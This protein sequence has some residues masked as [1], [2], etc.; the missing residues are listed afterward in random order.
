MRSKLKKRLL[1]NMQHSDFL[2]LFLHGSTRRRVLFLSAWVSSIRLG[3]IQVGSVP[4]RSVGFVR[5]S[6]TRFGSVPSHF[7]RFR[8]FNL[9]RNRF[10]SVR[11][12]NARCSVQFGSARF[13]SVRFG[14]V[15]LGSARFGCGQFGFDLRS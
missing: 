14:P 15:W 6:L 8:P 13:G 1:L 11:V 2:F 3:S 7:V 9:H 4:F 5:H 12:G 10:R